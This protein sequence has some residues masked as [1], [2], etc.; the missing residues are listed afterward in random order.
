[1]D[2]TTHERPSDR[3]TLPD[4]PEITVMFTGHCDIS[5]VDYYGWAEDLIAAGIATAEMLAP[6]VW[7]RRDADGDKFRLSRYYRLKDGQPHP[8]YRITRIKPD[9]RIECLPGA[10]A[11]MAAYERRKSW[12]AQRW[13]N[14]G[15][16]RR[17]EQVP[18]ARPSLRLV[19][20]NTRQRP[21]ADP[22]TQ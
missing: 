12:D 18:M 5:Q 4:F 10:R 3:I 6:R 11:A 21:A 1:M 13:E 2:E 20:D 17:L 7:K 15:A 9:A 8:C 22:L 16:R 19:V 14:I